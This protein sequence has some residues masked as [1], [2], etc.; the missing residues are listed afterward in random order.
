MSKQLSEIMR[1]C[2]TEIKAY[3]S[4]LCLPLKRSQC[5]TEIMAI[6]T[7]STVTSPLSELEIN[8]SILFYTEIIDNSDESL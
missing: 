5:I 3:K 8:A 1:K 2:L 7:K 6:L 4:G